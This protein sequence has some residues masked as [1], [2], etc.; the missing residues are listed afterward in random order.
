MASW[1]LWEGGVAE[2]PPGVGG[3]EAVLRN[4]RRAKAWRRLDAL[5]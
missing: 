2:V 5:A 4:G 1:C 3:G